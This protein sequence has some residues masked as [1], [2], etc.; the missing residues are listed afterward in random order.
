MWGLLVIVREQT[1]G[2]WPSRSRGHIR[3]VHTWDTLATHLITAG[4]SSKSESFGRIHL[5]A[6]PRPGS[7]TAGGTWKRSGSHSRSSLFWRFGETQNYSWGHLWM[8]KWSF[9]HIQVTAVQLIGRG[10]K[11]LEECAHL[12]GHSANQRWTHSLLQ[13]R[14]TILINDTAPSTFLITHNHI[15]PPST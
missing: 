6:Q 15:L 9:G 4:D 14:D 8:R 10:G 5:F 12:L 1:K 13:P 2:S 3:R 11:Y 7:N